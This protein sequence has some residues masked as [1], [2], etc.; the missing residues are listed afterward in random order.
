[1]HNLDK[2]SKIFIDSDPLLK[3]S[4]P[5][6]LYYWLTKQISENK[7]QQIRPFLIYFNKLRNEI[8]NLADEDIKQFALDNHLRQDPFDLLKYNVSLRSINNQKNL[9]IAYDILK[10]WFYEYVKKI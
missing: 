6:L 8:E 5:V 4:G 3:S 2:L 1:M 10:N 9:K 7:H